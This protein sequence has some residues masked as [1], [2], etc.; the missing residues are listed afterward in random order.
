M[1][2]IYDLLSQ[3][4]GFDIA[5]EADDITGDVKQGAS[6]VMGGQ[7]AD[8]AGKSD[9]GEISLNTDDIFADGPGDQKENTQKTD[10]P[11]EENNDET[12]DQPLD[13]DPQEDSTQMGDDENTEEPLSMK[14]NSPES[15]RKYKLQKQLLHFYEVLTGDIKLVSEFVPKVTDSE[16][17]QTLG[18]IRKNLMQ[19]R[20]YIYQ[21]ITEDLST[22]PYAVLM[23]KYVAINQVYGLVIRSLDQYFK[24]KHEE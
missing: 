24:N 15:L 23:K 11:G 1:G 7:S 4:N 5:T 12:D 9:D 20:D 3:V 14:D 8:P 21:L 19:C 10:E 18:S 13:D 17:I 2:I 22:Q 6:K 16:T